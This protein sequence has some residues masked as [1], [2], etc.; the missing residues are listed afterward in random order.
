VITAVDTNVLLDVFGADIS[1]G[2]RSANALRHCL[3]EGALVACEAVWAETGV[4][5]PA[6]MAP[7]TTPKMSNSGS[8]WTRN[9]SQRET[10]GRASSAALSGASDGSSQAR[11]TI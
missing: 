8:T 5:Q 6:V 2:V 10:P 7:T 3:R 1:H 11:S 9:G 4:A